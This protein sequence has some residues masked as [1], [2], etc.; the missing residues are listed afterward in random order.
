MSPQAR[1]ISTL[2]RLTPI[3]ITITITT[4]TL[5]T[6]TPIIITPII[7]IPQQDAPPSSP[8]SETDTT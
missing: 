5:T 1:K 7:I 3:T 6:I 8:Q 2:L 4:I